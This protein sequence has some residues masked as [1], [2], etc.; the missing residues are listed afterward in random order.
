MGHISRVVVVLFTLLAPASAALT[1]TDTGTIPALV[2]IGP[3]VSIEDDPGWTVDGRVNQVSA[4]AIR[5]V[6]AR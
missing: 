2:K 3:L 1:Q 6:P 4:A 5:Q